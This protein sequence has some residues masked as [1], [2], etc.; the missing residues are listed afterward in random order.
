MS[1]APAVRNFVGEVEGLVAATDDV[2]EIM[3][4]VGDLARPLVEDTAWLTERHFETDDDQGFGVTLV[5]KDP[6]DGL[7]IE[8]V[9]WAPGRG[10]APHDHRTWGVVIGLE[11]AEVN[12]DWKRLDD[13]TKDGFAEI[14]VARETVV[15]NGVVC[16]LMPDDIH[17]VRNEST[18]PSVSLHVYGRNLAVTGRSEYDPINKRVY[19]CPE[20]KRK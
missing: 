7:L 15:E 2:A 12:V 11:G 5:H 16:T 13:G 14:E 9:C 6:S 18:T 19:P 4:R 1:D 8:T 10:V 20:R 17:G 3:A